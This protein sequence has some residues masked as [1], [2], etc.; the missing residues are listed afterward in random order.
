MSSSFTCK[1]GAVFKWQIPAIEQSVVEIV[2]AADA[3]EAPMATPTSA[4]A[5]AMRSLMPSPQY[6]Q[7]LPIPCTPTPSHQFP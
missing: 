3:S 2:A 7:I 1:L 6:M 5:R 4:A